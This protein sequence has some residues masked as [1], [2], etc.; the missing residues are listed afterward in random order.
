SPIRFL[1]GR[2]SKASSTWPSGSRVDGG[3]WT[4]K[5]TGSLAPPA[6]SSTGGRSRST[7]RPSRARRARTHR[8]FSC[9][10]SR[11]S[12]GPLLPRSFREKS[13]NR[14]AVER[15]ILPKRFLNDG[16]CAGLNACGSRHDVCRVPPEKVDRLQSAHPVAVLLERRFVIAPRALLRLHDQIKRGPLGLEALHFLQHPVGHGRDVFRRRAEGHDDMPIASL[17]R[18]LREPD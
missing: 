2:S 9:G 12:V 11:L 14:V 7:P 10:C 4:T 8:G 1:T 16:W 17:G 3:W 18:R 15:K 5:P 6:R 13:H